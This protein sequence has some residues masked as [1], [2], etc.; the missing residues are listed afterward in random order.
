VK[1]APVTVVMETKYIEKQKMLTWKFRFSAD[2]S[3][4]QP[5]SNVR[6]LD[7]TF[8]NTRNIRLWNGGFVY[9]LEDGHNQATEVFPPREFHMRDHDLQKEG[10]LNFEDL[11]GRASVVLL[12]I[13]FLYGE[14]HGVWLAPEW[15]G[16]WAMQAEATPQGAVLLLPWLCWNLNT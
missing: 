2:R 11:L 13:W 9:N 14:A 16:S 8:E 1:D 10:P 5:I 4:Q 7:R 3:I 15:S 6:L 12:P